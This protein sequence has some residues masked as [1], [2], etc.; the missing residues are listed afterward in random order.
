[1]QAALL[2]LGGAALLVVFGVLVLAG[3]VAQIIAGGSTHIPTPALVSLWE[4][5]VAR[6]APAY[7]IPVGLDLG[8]ITHESGGDYLA[9]GRDR[10]GTSDAGLQQVNS[11]HW[12][13]YGMQ[14]DPYTPEANVIAGLSILASALRG[15]TLTDPQALIEGLAAYNG[16]EG[17]SQGLTY[18]GDV[19]AAAAG[20]VGPHVW[21]WPAAWQV[22]KG[23]LG[24][25]GGGQY[26]G[27]A[28]AGT[29]Q[30]YLVVTAWCGQ[31]YVGGQPVCGAPPW[32]PGE[33]Q[34]PPA[35]ATGF[36]APA[37]LTIQF[38]RP[39]QSAGPLL[40]PRPYGAAPKALLGMTPPDS[41][42]WWAVVP[43][44][45]RRNTSVTAT[46]TF[47]YA[48]GAGEATESITIIEEAH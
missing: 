44:G 6:E 23:V 47:G 16:S 12:A 28:L 42:Y 9:H 4:P 32:P 10:N 3:A 38:S 39:G 48:T 20:A 30:T 46:A 18:A 15:Y 5:L 29:G 36:A 40:V 27:P 2:V 26:T 14:R 25:A 35:W 45:T 17:T 1:M 43:V 22:R 21:V 37:Q 11:I 24:F 33:A 13:A 19:L 7:G 8:I 31:G 34:P 41:S